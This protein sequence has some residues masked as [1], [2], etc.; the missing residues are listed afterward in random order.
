M[1]KIR[2]PLYDRLPEIYRIKDAEQVP[3]G[4]LRVYLEAIEKALGEVHKN[5]ESLYHDFFIETCDDWVI[6]Y[7]GDLLGT[8]YLR[9]ESL[10]SRKDVASTV[11]LRRRKGTLAAIEQLTYNLTGWAV[12]CV[13]LMVNLAW[14]H[15]LNHQ[16]PDKGGQPPYSS[17][18]DVPLK[19]LDDFEKS[20]GQRAWVVTAV[21]VDSKTFILGW[22]KRVDNI[23]NSVILQIAE[24]PE[25][26]PFHPEYKEISIAFNQII[27]AR[28]IS[29]SL[30]SIIRGGTAAIRDQALLSLIGTPFDPFAHA[31]DLKVPTEGAIR[32]NIPNLAIFLWRLKDYRITASLPVWDGPDSVDTSGYQDQYLTAATHVLRLYVHPVAE[33]IELFNSWRFDPDSDP[34]VLTQID[35]IPGPI[36]EAR[37]TEGTPGGRPYEYVE[38]NTY[39]DDDANRLGALRIPEVGLQIHLPETIFADVKWTVRGANLCAWETGLLP[40]LLEHEAVIDPVIGRIAL[41]ITEDEAGA[42]DPSENSIIMTYSYGALGT[43][44]TSVGAHPLPRPATPDELH[45]ETVYKKYLGYDEGASGLQDALHHAFEHWDTDDEPIVIEIQSSRTYELN[46]A[47]LPPSAFVEIDGRFHLRLKNSLVIRSADYQRP[48]IKLTNPIGFRPQDVYSSDQQTQEE[49]LAKMDRLMVRL[50]GLYITRTDAFPPDQSL[51]CGAALNRLEILGCTLDPG[52]G[53]KLDPLTD[54]RLDS[55]RELI[56]PSMRLKIPF[57][58]LNGDGQEEDVFDQIPEI[59]VQHTIAGPLYTDREYKLHL[60]NSLIDAGSGVGVESPDFAVTGATGN[61]AES[62]GPPVVVNNATFFGRMRVE[63]IQGKGGIWVHGLEVLNN[64]IGCIKYSFFS[65]VH[66]RLPQNHGCVNGTEAELRFNSEVFGNPAYGQLHSRTDFRIRE[67]GPDDD[68]MGAF[69][70]L[71]TAHKWRNLQTRYLEFMPVG[72][73]PLLIPVT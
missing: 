20:K 31:A 5:I 21:L 71:N 36:P 64:Q 38:I 16:R 23:N 1:N 6:P 51:I 37:L 50:E 60:T 18:F 42:L 9:G 63:S 14:C 12:H 47:D 3:P 7:I 39:D 13:E 32:Y 15:H 73:R 35:E 56:W 72:I 66:D 27:E 69:G 61:A 58:S 55:V 26:P 44:E 4:Q 8:S 53:K 30:N 19:S 68:A 62:W 34:P 40:P 54:R 28:A 11:A 49:L 52:G 48:V 67:R 45:G 17:L 10:A 43:D 46:P 57:E 59:I 65:G 25:N 29:F 24:E 41:G 33:P 70:F 2:V 22:I